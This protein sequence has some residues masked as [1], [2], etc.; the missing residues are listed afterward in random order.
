MKVRINVWRIIPI[1][2]AIVIFGAAVMF[3]FTFTFF[4]KPIQQWD[5]IPYTLIGI[6][7]LLSIGLFVVTIVTSYYEVYRKYV[8]VH[9][10][11]KKLIYYYADVVYIDEEKSV[12]KKN[13]HFYTRQ[14]HA[15][16]LL[17]DKKGILYQTMITNCKNR[18]SKE[19]FEESHPNVKL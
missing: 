8:V 12:K 19:E 7:A 9:R 18:M 3:G 4:L 6:W 17:F 5:W 13:I 1:L 10:G 11:G 14:G 2:I 15:R 16:Y